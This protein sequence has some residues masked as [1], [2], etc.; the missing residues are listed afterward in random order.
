[1]IIFFNSS[2]LRIIIALNFT[3]RL[4]KKMLTYDTN[5][6]NIH[7][8][9]EN[10]IKS[11]NHFTS[12][13]KELGFILEENMQYKKQVDNLIEKFNKYVTDIKEAITTRC[14]IISE[15]QKYFDVKLKEVNEEILKSQRDTKDRG[16]MNRLYKTSL[17]KTLEIEIELEKLDK[18]LFRSN[19]MHLDEIEKVLNEADECQNKEISLPDT[20]KIYDCTITSNI[21]E[22]SKFYVKIQN[23]DTQY[24]INE[25]SNYIRYKRITNSKWLTFDE[26]E[27]MPKINGKCFFLN[28]KS[29]KWMRGKIENIGRNIKMCSIRSLDIGVRQFR[30]DAEHIID[31][32]D[33]NLNDKYDFRSIRCKFNDERYNRIFDDARVKSIYKNIKIAFREYS[34]SDDAWLIDIKGDLDPLGL[35]VLEIGKNLEKNDD[36]E[37]NFFHSF[38][39]SDVII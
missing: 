27:I 23:K 38:N 28:E 7:Q 18:N 24:V 13:C 12:R 17:Y 35:E 34:E 25:L 29:K 19:Y 37:S 26:V 6:S 9:I 39:Y 30:V 8:N 16:D 2:Y 33:F 22:F 5:N 31:W 11:L 20:N 1:M 32:K 10:L 15:K 21:S 4:L 3:F 36:S 14:E